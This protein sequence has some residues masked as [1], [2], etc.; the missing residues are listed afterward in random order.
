VAQYLDGE[1]DRVQSY[2]HSSTL[3]PLIK[4]VE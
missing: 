2:L 1:K 3:E 4:I